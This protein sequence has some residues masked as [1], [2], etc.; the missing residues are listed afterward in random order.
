MSDSSI[1]E[2]LL[3]NSSQ[4]IETLIHESSRTCRTTQRI[5]ADENIYSETFEPETTKYENNDNYEPDAS[6]IQKETNEYSEI[7]ESDMS[8]TQKI[9]TKQD[10]SECFD[11]ESSSSK[12]NTQSYSDS[13]C[14]EPISLESDSVQLRNFIERINKNK[15]KKLGEINV[16]KDEFDIKLNENYLENVIN[17]IK[18]TKEAKLNIPINEYLVNRL[19]MK[20]FIEENEKNYEEKVNNFGLNLIHE[21]YP[22]TKNKDR[23]KE[24]KDLKEKH[25]FKKKCD[26]IKFKQLSNK[27]VKHEEIYADGIMLIGELARDLP[28]HTLPSDQ[29]WNMFL[30]PLKNQK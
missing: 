19:K 23:E 2:D 3:L 26:L 7:F 25:Y 1:S 15:I 18:T 14:S 8:K 5:D 13:F 24:L 11:Y 30:S 4:Q 16:P 29:V 27:I 9:N 17:R 6:F 12:E 10:Y 22:E 20:L 28:K 21:S